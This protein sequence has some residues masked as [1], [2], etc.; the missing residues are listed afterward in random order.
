MQAL[1]PSTSYMKAM[2]IILPPFNF[3]MKSTSTTIHIYCTTS[4]K[5]KD[6]REP[7]Q[8]NLVPLSTPHPLSGDKASHTAQTG[9]KLKTGLEVLSPPPEVH[10]HTQHSSYLSV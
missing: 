1:P 2:S 4:K 3:Y 10:Q 7:F 5:P 8:E 9:L 6:P